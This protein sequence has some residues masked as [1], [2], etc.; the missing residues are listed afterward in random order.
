VVFHDVSGC[1][2]L[3]TA[4]SIPTAEKKATFYLNEWVPRS[5]FRVQERKGFP[6]PGSGFRGYN[7]FNP[8]L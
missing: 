1:T 8:E 3:C 5:R 6:V 7:G 2:L 4:I